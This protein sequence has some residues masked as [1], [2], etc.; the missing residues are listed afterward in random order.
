M[1]KGHTIPLLQFGRILLNRHVAVTMVLSMSLFDHFALSTDSMQPHFEQVLEALPR[2][3]FMVT[4]G[5]LWWTLQ[6]AN[7]FKI[8]RLF[9]WATVGSK[10]VGETLREEPKAGIVEGVFGGPQP[11]GEL[12]DLTQFPWIRLCKDDVEAELRNL[13]AGSVANE[14]NMKSIGA[15]INSY[16]VVENSFYELE[17]ALLTF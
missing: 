15:T 12:V 13:E 14:F 8:R 9:C 5:F 3:S 10:T 16:G 4:D 17:P 1:A 2:V 7:K 11:V 6:S